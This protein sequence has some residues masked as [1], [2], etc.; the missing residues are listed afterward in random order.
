MSRQGPGL[1]T[2][3]SFSFA[4]KAW[5]LIGGVTLLRA[6]WILFVPLDL[7]EDEA[8]Y[9][10]WS[11]R[12][13]WGYYSKPPMVAWVI[14]AATRLFGAHAAVVRLPAVLFG[15]LGMAGAYAL[16]R[17]MFDSRTAFWSLILLAVAPGSMSLGLV[18]TIDAPLVAFWCVALYAVW[19]AV[20]TNAANLGWWLLAGLLT[21]LGLLAKQ[22]MIVLPVAV[23]VYLLATPGRRHLR[24]VG[25]Y[26]CLGLAVLAVLPVLAWN[27]RHGWI[28]FHHTAHH[29][30]RDSISFVDA[31]QS[32]GVFLAG[33]LLVLSPL[34]GM[35]FGLVGCSLLA[36]LRRRRAQVLFLTLLGPLP[37]FLIALGSFR[38]GI[39][40]NWPAVFHVC[41]AILVAA[42]LRDRLSFTPRV[43]RTR[44]WLRPALA[45]AI[46]LCVLTYSVPFVAKA[47]RFDGARYDPM[48][49]MRGWS[50]LGTAMTGIMAE[51]PRPQRTFVMAWNRQAASALAFYMSGQPHVYVWNPEPWIVRSQY[52]LWD[53][54]G[55][56]L[57]WDALLLVTPQTPLHFM[58][59][60]RFAS[61]EYLGPLTVPRGAMGERRFE[62]YRGSNL[63]RWR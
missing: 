41:S 49:R 18:M 13:D 44:A 38:Q 10:D 24:R 26:A 14:G 39:N 59:A 27:A 56:R 12:L 7:L 17:R 30:A 50:Q 54:P 16:A 47:C 35:L 61:V 58:L 8:Y 29:F 60:D 22:M 4:H 5:I 63:T 45:V 42:W 36:G 33:Q 62:L 51:Q 34:L 6:V 20:D 32:F 9:W 21:G 23:L 57:G 25:P 46:L 48:R 15:A 55:D 40:A 3:R 1:R 2:R 37:V 11:R 43:D 53:P 31:L 19:R 52:D 28:T